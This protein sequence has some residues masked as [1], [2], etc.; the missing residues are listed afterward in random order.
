MVRVKL[1]RHR[2]HTMTESKSGGEPSSAKRAKTDE[3]QQHQNQQQ[4]LAP[5]R[6]CVWS[7]FLEGRLCD[8]KLGGGMPALVHLILAHVGPFKKRGSASRALS[9]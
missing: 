2:A 3:Q 6:R 8:G 7:E 9:T 1:P 4:V 5:R